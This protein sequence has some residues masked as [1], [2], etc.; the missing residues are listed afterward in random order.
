MRTI[1]L[2]LLIYHL[3]YSQWSTSTYADSALYVCPGFVQAILTFDDGASVICGALDDSRY[4][5]KLDPYG[6][7]IWPQ[8]VQIMNTPGTGNDGISTPIS[9]GNGGCFV[10]WNDYRGA[11]CSISDLFT[12]YFNN[13]MYMQHI[14]KNGNI[15]QQNGGIQIDS[16]AGGQKWGYGVMDGEGGIIFYMS[17]NIY[18]TLSGAFL[19]AHTW[20]VRYNGSGQKIWTKEIDT[21]SSELNSSQPIK[22]GNRIMIRTLNGIRFIN[23]SSGETQSQPA[24]VPDG[25]FVI[26]GDTAAFNV[27]RVSDRYDSVGRKYREYLVTRININWDF[28]WSNKFEILDAG[29]LY[30]TLPIN[31]TVFPDRVGGLFFWEPSSNDSSKRGVRLRRITSYSS[32]FNTDQ[33]QIIMDPPSAGFGFNGVGKCGIYFDNGKT[34]EFDTTGKSLWPD[35]YTVISDPSNA[36]SPLVGSDNNGG[37]IITYWSTLGGIFAQHTGRVGKVGIITNVPTNKSVPLHF[38]LSQNFPNPFNPTTTINFE[39]ER[40][41]FTTLKVFDILGREVTT[42]VA[43]ELKPGLYSRPWHA[44]H[45]SSGIYFY[46][47]QSGAYRETKKMLLLK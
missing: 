46:L 47:L 43:E 19:K 16:V 18:D 6:Y 35:N 27:K 39:L 20:L 29:D 14:D 25:N 1:V 41:S 10:C 23:P 32:Q 8:P 38:D 40:T 22:L 33:I 12:F 36:Y 5:Q 42:L 2:A 7:K 17:E 13:A 34:F 28:S 9:D 37:G 11:S 26:D 44:L 3:S 24:F 4:A 30:N 15:L 45:C 31:N 21:S